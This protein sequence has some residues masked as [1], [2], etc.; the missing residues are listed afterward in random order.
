M[1]QSQGGETVNSNDKADAAWDDY[2]SQQ[3]E[4]KIEEL[5]RELNFAQNR[6]KQLEEAG[7]ELLR[8]NDDMANINRWLRAKEA[9][10]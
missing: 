7:D 6:I 1:E 2:V 3:Q 4:E 8:D 9:K 5:Q 10:P